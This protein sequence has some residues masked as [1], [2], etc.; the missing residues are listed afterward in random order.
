MGF[1]YQTSGIELP[2]KSHDWSLLNPIWNSAPNVENAPVAQN[3]QIFEDALSNFMEIPVVAAT[4]KS[5]L[6]DFKQQWIDRFN[7]YESNKTA[8][9]DVLN[10]SVSRVLRD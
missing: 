4:L 9:K 3:Q 2:P 1:S 6:T 10:N 5:D 8:A 7:A